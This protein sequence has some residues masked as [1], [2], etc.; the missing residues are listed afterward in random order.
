MSSGPNERRE[1]AAAEFAEAV[2]QSF[3]GDV[4]DVILYGSTARGD[5]TEGSDVDVL[6][7]IREGTPTDELFQHSFDIGLKHGVPIIPHVK[8][9]TEFETRRNHPFF[10]TVR[11]EGQ[12]Y[13]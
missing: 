11:R 3:G 6:V 2:R 10:E 1:T 4:H 9:K 5:A 7:V 8:T 13:G 12:S